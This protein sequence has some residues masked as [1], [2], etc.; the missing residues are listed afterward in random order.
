MN[1]RLAL[2]VLLVEALAG[3]IGIYALHIAK[4][5]PTRDKHHMRW[6]MRSAP[7]EI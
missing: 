7:I 2:Q 6:G 5:P 4:S 3:L 1:C